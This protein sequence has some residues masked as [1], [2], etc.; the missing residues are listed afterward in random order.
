MSSGDWDGCPPCPGAVWCAARYPAANM[1]QFLLH[2][3]CLGLRS[4]F[5]DA[6]HEARPKIA[7]ACRAVACYRGDKGR[8]TIWQI[9]RYMPGRINY[10]L[11]HRLI[12]CRRPAYI[13]EVAYK[14]GQQFQAYICACIRHY[15]YA[16]YTAYMRVPQLALARHCADLQCNNAVQRTAAIYVCSA[17]HCCYICSELR[18]RIHAIICAVLCRT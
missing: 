3:Q 7:L 9:T 1:R 17:A 15:L 16:H 11:T 10:T 18:F 2:S 5:S 8:P 12:R 4:V 14:C 6:M 13:P